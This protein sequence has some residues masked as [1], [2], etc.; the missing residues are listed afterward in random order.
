MKRQGEEIK[1]NCCVAYEDNDL[2]GV[3]ERKLLDT[4]TE[5]RVLWNEVKIHFMH[6]L[7]SF[8]SMK[9]H[10]L[11]SAYLASISHSTLLQKS[12]SKGEDT[13]DFD[14]LNNPTFLKV[15]K[16]RLV[17]CTLKFKLSL[18]ISLFEISI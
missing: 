2:Q 5:W 10:Q 4:Y 12:I 15:K 6:N 13:E 9:K 11:D 1:R 3:E 8:M 16:N 7:L 17:H 14:T 18:S